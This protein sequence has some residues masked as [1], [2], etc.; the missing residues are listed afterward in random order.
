MARCRWL[1]PALLPASG[2]AL[3]L[4]W[5]HYATSGNAMPPP[6][7]YH[8][9][10]SGNVLL[11]WK[12]CSHQKLWN[13]KTGIFAKR[14]GGQAGIMI[15]SEATTPPAS[16]NTY[17]AADPTSFRQHCAAGLWLHCAAGLRPPAALCHWP[18]KTPASGNTMPPEAHHAAAL[19][20]DHVS[21]CICSIPNFFARYNVLLETLLNDR[22]A[23][24]KD[25]A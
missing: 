3:P 9:T 20:H 1:H 15:K 22:G 11:C 13:V 8:H 21:Y 25:S 14:T 24:N 6:T 10:A 5:R 17:G 23:D 19:W 2:N 12:Q 7:S 18:L 4:V 16:G